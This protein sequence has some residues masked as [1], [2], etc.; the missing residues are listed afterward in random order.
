MEYRFLG[1]G[2]ALLHGVVLPAGDIDILVKERRGVEVFN[3]ALKCFDCLMAPTFLEDMRQFYAEFRVNGV[4]VGISTVE[5]EADVDWIET[6]GSGP[7]THFVLLSCGLD[8][9]GEA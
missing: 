9:N 2:A 5:I 1:T 3:D 8:S 4:E 6:Y 7:W